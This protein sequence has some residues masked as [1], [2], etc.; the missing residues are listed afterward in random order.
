MILTHESGAQEDQFDEK[1]RRP[2]ISWYYP[3]KQCCRYVNP[4][5]EYM[6][7]RCQVMSLFAMGKVNSRVLHILFR[8]DVL[9]MCIFCGLPVSLKYILL[10]YKA[11]YVLGDAGG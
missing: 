9:Y 11:N 5:L 4:P 10:Q 3:F 7:L 1:K 2:K 6:I 8:H